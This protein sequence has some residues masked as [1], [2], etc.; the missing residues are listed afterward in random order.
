MKIWKVPSQI[1]ASNVMNRNKLQ[2]LAF[3]TNLP[4]NIGFDNRACNFSY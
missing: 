2:A 1:T 3:V 4:L